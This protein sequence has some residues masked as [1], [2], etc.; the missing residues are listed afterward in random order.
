MPARVATFRNWSI[1]SIYHL[2][3]FFVILNKKHHVA[4]KKIRLF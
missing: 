4:R 3:T 2:M 1:L